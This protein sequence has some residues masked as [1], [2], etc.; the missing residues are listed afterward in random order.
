MAAHNFI[1]AL[2]VTHDC[3]IICLLET[4]LDLSISNDD[5]RIKIKGC[6][7]LRADHP[8]NKKR[9]GVC[10]YYKELF[11][12]IKRYYSCTLKECL[13][14]EIIVDKKRVSSCL[15]VSPCRTQDEF[16]G[17]CN[18]NRRFIYF[19]TKLSRQWSLHKDNAERLEN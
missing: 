4:F 8:S 12:I 16:E 9:G 10:M 1:K 13:V 7:L 17:F 14:T 19:N 18:D 3:D 15:Y 6:S 5:E 2:C 11:S